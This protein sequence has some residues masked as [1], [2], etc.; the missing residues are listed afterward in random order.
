MLE[1]FIDVEINLLF[2]YSLCVEFVPVYETEHCF[3]KQPF[4]FG[5]LQVIVYTAL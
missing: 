1:R 3:C 2:C 4:T 5:Q